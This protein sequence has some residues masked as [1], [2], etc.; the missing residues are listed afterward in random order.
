L[1]KINQHLF[2]LDLF[3]AIAGYGVAICHFYYYIYDQSNYQF[4]SLFFVE[5]FFVLSGF[6]LY[7]QLLKVYEKNKNLKIFFMRR[8]LRTIPLYI[9]ALFCYSILF[10]KFDWDTLKYLFFVQHLANNFLLDDY[11]SVAW[12]LSVEEIFYIIFPIFLILLKKRS[13]MEII[14]IFVAIIYLIKIFYISFGNIDNEFFRIGTFLRLDSIAFGLVIRRYYIKVNKVSL[15]ILSAAIIIILFNFTKDLNLFSKYEIFFFILIVQIF[16]I[17]LITIF[18]YL[19]KFVKKKYLQ[20]TFSLLSK[21]T[22]SVYLFHFF[23]I[24][25]L[26]NSLIFS[27]NSY[28]FL[29]YLISL[30]LISTLSYYLFEK[31]ILLKRPNY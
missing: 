1:N 19:N 21:Q 20:I 9:L 26:K 10:S 27:N 8:W 31:P 24:Y 25:F 18:V 6:V 28:I 13:F 5:F 2:S 11:F 15:H 4:Y 7:P 22:Y 30:F 17:N 3:R 12:S 14:L 16:S 29:I 23:P